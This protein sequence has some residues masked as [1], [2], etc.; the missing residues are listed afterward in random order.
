MNAI[1]VGVRIATLRKH[2]GLT[3]KQLAEKLN[4]TDKAVSK[5]ERG[6]NFPDLTTVESLAFALDISA[7]EL[8]G[9][10]KNTAEEAL[11]A[12]AIIYENNKNRWLK[13][14]RKGIWLIIVILGLL[15]GASI[16]LSWML[17]QQ[18]IYGLAQALSGGLS[19]FY[20]LLIG[21][22]FYM[23][24]LVNKQSLRFLLK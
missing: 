18:G 17:H 3:Q 11:S 8:L 1:E 19:G 4:V 5:W 6:L 15:W 24:R 20:G 9:L 2:K 7:A 23:L 12:S 16:W 22:S 21:S 10:T 13:E 14:L